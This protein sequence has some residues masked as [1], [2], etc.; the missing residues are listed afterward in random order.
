MIRPGRPLPAGEFPG[1]D[2]GSVSLSDFRQRRGLVLLLL[3]S[4]GEEEAALVEEASRRRDE[5][6]SHGAA[7]FGILPRRPDRGVPPFPSPVPVLFDEPGLF[8]RREG[9]RD[10]AE[11]GTSRIAVADRY[12]QVYVVIPS[13]PGAER[14]AVSEALEWVGYLDR[15]CPE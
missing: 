5:F 15:Q 11:T 7:L 12:G 2:G 9:G 14:A 4:G 8:L 3:R 1:A 10:P 13:P 6:S